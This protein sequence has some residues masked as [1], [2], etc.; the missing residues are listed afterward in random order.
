[1]R[2]D[3][4]TADR[5]AFLDRASPAMLAYVGT[6][7]EDGTPHVVPVWFRWDGDALTIWTHEDRPWVRNL[8]RDQRVTVVIAEDEPPF[9]GV[10]MQGTVETRTADDGETM[11]EIRAITRR[12]LPEE[13]VDA[14]VAGWPNL[15]TI[16]R[17]RPDRI[18]AWGRGY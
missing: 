15:R 7:F 18:R 8:R 9:A 14:Y 4:E 3:M 11:A 5:D 2:Y 1:M 13:E 12:Y 17:L 6:T 16:A 10:T